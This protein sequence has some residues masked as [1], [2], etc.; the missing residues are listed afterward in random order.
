MLQ[1]LNIHTYYGDSHV[2]RD[3]TVRVEKGTV[4]A[5][6]G[7]NGVGKTTLCRSIMGFT[8]PRAGRVILGDTEITRMPPYRICRMRVGLIPQG[9]RIFPSLTVREN[10]A[11]AQDASSGGWT[12]DRIFSLF[13]RLAERGHH[14]GNEL[15]GGEQQMLAIARALISNPILLVMDEPTEGL[16]PALV[17]EVA[18][19]IRRLKDE[20]TSVLL[21][22]Q[23]AAFAVK[24]ADYV[25]VM[26]KGTIVHSS[27]PITLWKNEDIK[28]QLLGVPSPPPL[29]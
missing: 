25:H 9:R 21:V 5:V 12:L 28:T 29:H 7:R 24:V 6:L 1:I 17:A 14:R 20:G 8:P 10:L 22:E 23:N 13:P 4:A 3:V 15:S 19:L 26:S 27:D 11:I 2:L 18:R 16:S